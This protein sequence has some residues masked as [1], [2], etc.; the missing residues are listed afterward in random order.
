MNFKVRGLFTFKGRNIRLSFLNWRE[1][2]RKGAL[3]RYYLHQ[4]KEDTRSRFGR[5]LD[6]LG[7]LLLAWLAS[8]LLLA[9]FTGRPVVALALSMPLLAAETLLLKKLWELREKRR[10]L[11]QRLWLA[12]QKFME[13][14]LKMDPQKEFTPY[15]RDILTALPG[16]QEMKLKEAKKNGNAGT[17]QGIDLEFLYKGTPVAIRCMRREGDK[18]IA[19]DDIRAFAG[20]LHLGGYKNGLFVTSGDFGPGVLR[21]VGEAARKG[22][23]IKPVDRYRLMDLARQA[24]SGAF[25]GEEAA[26]GAPSR[27]AGERRAAALA[28]FRDSALGSRK[29][30]R[31]YFFYGL[32][33][34]GGYVLL[35][36]TTLLGPVYLFFALVNFLMGAGSLY[37][38]KT[39]EEMDPLEGL[40]SDQ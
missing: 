4:P 5:R 28:A 25:R 16:F 26:P 19:P 39:L 23:N 18:K 2:Y 9:N 12:G 8:F 34:Y 37:F 32:L 21:V 27:T 36:D 40:G 29:K 33:L 30:A 13:D 31:S 22:I 24:G 7:G 38:G 20:A 11:Q 15:V 14:I 6:I 10:R 3:L 1:R 35:K 17:K